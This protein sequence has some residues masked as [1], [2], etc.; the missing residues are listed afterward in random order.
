MQILRG[1]EK[2]Y[3]APLLFLPHACYTQG[4]STIDA[5]LMS[6]MHLSPRAIFNIGVGEETYSDVEALLDETKAYTRYDHAD[7]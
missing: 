3:R 1:E 7:K 6:L 4:F 5:D 2:T